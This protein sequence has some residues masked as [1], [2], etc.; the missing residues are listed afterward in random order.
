MRTNLVDTQNYDVSMGTGLIRMS[1][2]GGIAG[3]VF[4][5]GNVGIGKSNPTSAL[6]VSGTMRTNLIDTQ[7]FDISMG[8]GQIR[9]SGGGTFTSDNS[10]N[11]DWI[12]RASPAD[13][14][15][16]G[17]AYGNGLFVVV[18]GTDGSNN[19]VMTSPNGINWT[20]RTTP[21]PG[22]SWRSITFGTP[23]S[24]PNGLFVAV[25][26]GGTGNR[27]M[28]S[29]DGITWTSVAASNN[30]NVWVSIAYGSGYFVATAHS[31]DTNRIMY[32]SNGT[33][34][35]AVA[36][37]AT[38]EGLSVG[39]GNGRFV[40]GSRGSSNY[41][42]YTN[43]NLSLNPPSTA[44]WAQSNS[45][46]I[47][48]WCSITYGNGLFVAVSDAYNI[49]GV[50][51]SGTGGQQ[52]TSRVMTSPDGITWSNRYAPDIGWFGITYGAGMFVACSKST[53]GNRTM[54][55]PDGINWAL[56]PSANDT[57][58]WSGIT[59]GN[60]IFVTVAESGG[61][62]S[63]VMTLDPAY[64]M[65]INK[66][67][68]EETTTN[69]V[70]F[71]QNGA[72]ISGNP[73]KNFAWV[74][75]S[76]TEANQWHSVC[77]GNGIFVAVA[78][79]GTNRVMTSTDG[80]TWVARSAATSI[81]WVSVCYGELSGNNLYVAVANT[82]SNRVM[83]ST[84]G[85]SWTAATSANESNTWRNICFGYDTS[86]NGRFVSVANGG[87]GARVMTSSNG[88]NWTPRNSINDGL[89]WH[90]ACYGYDSSGQGQFVAVGYAGTGN[91]SMYSINGGETWTGVTTLNNNN[92]LWYSV[93][94]GNGT[95]VAVG[96]GPV[97]T[98]VMYSRNIIGAGWTA[99]NYPVE[100]DWFNVCFGNGLFVATATSGV[101][102]RVMTSPDGIN[103]T[104]RASTE[105]N[106]WLSVCYGNGTFVA[107]SNNG[108][109][110]V[111]TNDYNAN[112]NMLVL[113]GGI[114]SNVG[115]GTNK[116]TNNLTVAT[117][118]N[119]GGIT[120]SG[121]SNTTLTLTS[122]GSAGAGV[123]R[124]G[125]VSIKAAD[126]TDKALQF[127]NSSSDLLP[128][129]VAYKFL[130]KGASYLVGI[131]N[132]GS[133]GIGT[134][135]PG[136]RLHVNYFGSD[137]GMLHTNCQSNQTAALTAL[138]N[139]YT[140]GTIFGPSCTDTQLVFYSKTNNNSMLRFLLTGVAFFTGQHAVVMDKPEI[141]QNLD[142][143]VGLI[144]SSND[145][146]CTSY[147]NGVKYTGIDAIRINES[148]PNCKLS[149]TDNDKAVYGVITNQKNDEYFDDSGNPM[150]DNT[151]DGFDRQLFDRV[152]V[153]SVGEG[154]IWV[155]NINGNI[156]NGDYITSSIIPGY[157][158]K[159][160]DDILHSYTVGKS[161]MSCDFSLSSTR[162]KTK[163]IEFN[164][165]TYI[166]AF[167]GCTYHCG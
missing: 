93:C 17:I 7:N 109:N 68:T 18:S 147:Y 62:G 48:R 47:L 65:S 23:T 30:T 139:S 60:G 97:G 101:G 158:K 54:T 123:V 32:S 135:G 133:V 16:R 148:L 57:L 41:V 150:Y 127:F 35:T 42:L 151:D 96:N 38:F 72:T 104:I 132:G 163:T 95:F 66:I 88:I 94:Y 154:S 53:T 124:T 26:D 13:Y 105:D 43:T 22:A 125:L 78:I 136:S 11:Y 44:N 131:L 115:I 28:T 143:Y 145:T 63:R 8:T 100:I 155:T 33:T 120:V 14:I 166:A 25:A 122:T 69:L 1:G 86:G 117:T 99:A 111:M 126:T 108:T 134:S 52:L 3:N 76:A 146:G 24:N 141:T 81:Q 165:E 142:D 79:D 113:N 2:G 15:W 149:D 39:F 27:V 107:V 5:N 102:N 10:I 82:G 159:Q 90:A 106:S 84:N 80:Y 58:N 9:M 36:T 19:S 83:Y 49:S 138:S 98:K 161:I 37:G 116:P 12:A 85:T 21:N 71:G 137:N 162:Y 77:Y 119:G 140:T 103:W 128:S 164:G 75:R 59:Y 40:V 34:W 156:E 112:D 61:S 45:V 50:P 87:T 20:L 144:I 92:S 29:S 56:R 89:A 129:D 157:G 167:I 118:A 114:S 67:T 6:D 70:K 55:S 4:L 91:R 152:R 153:N 121:T 130:D 51:A 74:A 46:N 110:R 160:N 31:G 73:S 64:G